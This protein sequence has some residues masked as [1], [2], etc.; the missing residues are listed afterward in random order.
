MRPRRGPERGAG[1]S[2][3]VRHVELV[4]VRRHER[5]AR[6][7]RPPGGAILNVIVRS[8]TMSDDHPPACPHCESPR[9]VKTNEMETRAF[10]FCLTCGRFFGRRVAHTAAET[11]KAAS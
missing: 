6:I 7:R 1:H 5:R 4:C 10:Y 2:G 8:I 11:S 9:I 3:G